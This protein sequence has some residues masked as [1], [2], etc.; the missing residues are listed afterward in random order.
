MKIH[1][2]VLCILFSF[3]EKL[4]KRNRKDTFVKDNFTKKEFYI[5]MRDGVKL[6]LRYIFRKIYRTKTNIRS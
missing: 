4:R 2:S 1:I 3:L 6:L 5:P